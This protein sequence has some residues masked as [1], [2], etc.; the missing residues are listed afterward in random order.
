MSGTRV[1][2]SWKPNLRV[3]YVGIVIVV[4]AQE[5]ILPARI[6]GGGGGDMSQTGGNVG[7]L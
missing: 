5:G 1:K 3:I 7:K 4:R 2:G 6:C